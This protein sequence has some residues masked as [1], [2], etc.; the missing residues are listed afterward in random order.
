MSDQNNDWLFQ[1]LPQA[2]PPPS[3]KPKTDHGKALAYLKVVAKHVG[4]DVHVALTGP[5]GERYLVTDNACTCF[6]KDG[7]YVKTM[8][9][10]EF[11]QLGLDGVNG[12]GTDGR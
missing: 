6:D 9:M 8:S 4:H 7:A 2:P 12:N 11:R 10:A 3:R 5:S 1:P